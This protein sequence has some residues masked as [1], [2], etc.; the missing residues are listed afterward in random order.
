MTALRYID[1]VLLW[2]T[3]PLA[4]VLG[5]P[6][7]GLLLAAVVW[8]VQRL[9]ALDV[10]RRAR[11]RASAREAIGLNMA[12]MIVRMWLIGATVVVAGVGGERRDGVAAAAVLLV[13][14]TISLAATL[15][16]RS[17]SRSAPR[18]GTPTPA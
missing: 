12:T 11:L 6:Q 18:P 14:F 13:A 16:N 4:L 9:V 17:L 1:L 15:V 3:V 7:L 2:L 8:T 10:D 5:A